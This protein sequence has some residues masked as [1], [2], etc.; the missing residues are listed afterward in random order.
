MVYTTVEIQTYNVVSLL[1]VFSYRLSYLVSNYAT[2]Q[3]I[4]IKRGKFGLGAFAVNRILKGGFI[5]G[6]SM[7]F[8]AS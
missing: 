2:M 7:L 5:G 4:E 8:S 1:W 3:E 6:T